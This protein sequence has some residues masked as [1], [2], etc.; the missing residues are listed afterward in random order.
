[1]PF[2]PF[3]ILFLLIIKHIKACLELLLYKT[4]SI[5]FTMHLQKNTYI[6][7]RSFWV[8][9]AYKRVVDYV[10]RMAYFLCFRYLVWS[11][12]LII[13]NVFFHL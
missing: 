4:F 12:C 5:F 13:L 9:N 8:H 7:R 3:S 10:K 2:K 6:N 11:E 1:M